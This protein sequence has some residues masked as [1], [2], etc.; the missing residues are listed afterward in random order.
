MPAAVPRRSPYWLILFA[1]AV[2]EVVG[3]Y[4]VQARVVSD[5]DWRRA[6]ARVRA[7]WEPGDLVVPAP[8]WT[9]PLVRRELGDL[10]SLSDV[11]RADLSR[12]QRLWAMSIRGFRPREAPAAAPDHEELVGPIHI[13]RWDLSP[14]QVLYDFLEHV[15][16]AR[17]TM[18]GAPCRFQRARPRGGGLGAGPIEAAERH[19][20][21][22]RR[23]WLWVGRTMQEDLDLRPRHCI[24]QHPAAPEVIRATFTDVPLGDRVELAGDLYYEHERMREHGPLSVA[25]F[26]DDVE[27]GRMVHRDGEGWKGLVASTRVPSRGDRERADISVEVTAPNPHLRSFCWAATVRAGEPR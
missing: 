24:W 4:V 18:D 23:P 26:L 6:S 5:D 14:A 16:E 13:L 17:V 20:C 9:D 7:Q 10:L 8:E 21:D 15:P 11:G 22:P 3:H 1:I 12:H 19:L 27:I 25:V 2:V